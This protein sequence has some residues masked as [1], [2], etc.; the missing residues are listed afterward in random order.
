MKKTSI[1]KQDRLN[2]L[3]FQAN[4]IDVINPTLDEDHSN[5]KKF[6]KL[7][8][9]QKIKEILKSSEYALTSSEP[10][11]EQQ[12]ARIQNDL[13]SILDFDP[14]LIKISELLKEAMIHLEKVSFRF[15]KK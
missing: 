4:E 2:L 14:N 5:R 3:E 10:S 15:L 12:V 6:K 13:I 11:V 8:N 9:I 7:N 1:E